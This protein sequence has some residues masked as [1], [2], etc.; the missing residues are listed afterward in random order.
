MINI[1]E[2]KKRKTLMK[3]LLLYY[4]YTILLNYITKT[5]QKEQLELT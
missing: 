3:R 5:R 4:Y 1:F 2:L